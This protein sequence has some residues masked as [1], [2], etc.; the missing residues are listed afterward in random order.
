MLAARGARDL[1]K[2]EEKIAD[3]AA[4]AVLRRKASGIHITAVAFGIV[5][6]AIAFM[7]FYEL[8]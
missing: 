4:A 6:A 2:G 7:L 1:D 3:P 8:Y 5:L